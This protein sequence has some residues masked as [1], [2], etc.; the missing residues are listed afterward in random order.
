M[1]MGR[2]PIRRLTI[3]VN[4]VEITKSVRA[5]ADDPE[6]P[7]SYQ[8]IYNRLDAGVEPENAVFDAASRGA[9]PDSDGIARVLPSTSGATWL[10]DWC[11][12]NGIDL[13]DVAVRL[14]VSYSTVLNLVNGKSISYSMV[15]KSALLMDVSGKSLAQEFGLP[16]QFGPVIKKHKVAGKRRR[17]WQ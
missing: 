6:C 17:G 4:G 15:F 10:L 1:R 14:E 3:K 11:K 12:D 5:W 13:H 9:H 2:R 8:T 16:T 7:V